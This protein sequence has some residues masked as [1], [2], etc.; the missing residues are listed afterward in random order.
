MKNEY[1]YI[2]EEILEE[3]ASSYSQVEKEVLAGKL[4]ELVCGKIEEILSK[5]NE[6]HLT[7][8]SASGLLFQ[9]EQWIKINY[10]VGGAI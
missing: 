5:A 7:C 6:F 1:L 8:S 2:A 9:L 4:K 10:D 3:Y